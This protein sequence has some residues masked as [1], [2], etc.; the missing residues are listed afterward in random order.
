MAGRTK[1]LVAAAVLVIPGG[2]VML[3]GFV[4]SHAVWEGFQIVRRERPGEVGLRA[5]WEATRFR[6]SWERTRAWL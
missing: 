1:V 4:L 6:D 5:V 2:L 3:L